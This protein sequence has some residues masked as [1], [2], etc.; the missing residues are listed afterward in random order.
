MGS[1]SWRDAEDLLKQ[2]ALGNLSSRKFNV[3]HFPHNL[4]WKLIPG[5]SYV[6][7]TSSIK[8][9][10]A[11]LDAAVLSASPRLR[12]YETLIAPELARGQ[13]NHSGVPFLLLDYLIA[14]ALLLTTT[15]QEWLDRP[16]DTRLP[17]S[18]SRTVQKWLAI[19]HSK[20]LPVEEEQE[21]GP[22]S[23]NAGN[24]PSSPSTPSTRRASSSIWD[25]HTSWSSNSGSGSGGS[26]QVATPSTPATTPSTHSHSSGFSFARGLS[27]NQQEN[28]PPVPPLPAVQPPSVVQPP[29]QQ[30][31][32]FEIA[33]PEPSPDYYAS[34]SGSEP[35]PYGSQSAGPSPSYDSMSKA[36]SSS[37]HPFSHSPFAPLTSSSSMSSVRRPRQLP[38]PP[39]LQNAD[40]YSQ[41]QASELSRV[42]SSPSSLPYSAHPSLHTSASYANLQMGSGPRSAGARSSMRRSIR[43]IPPPPPPPQH[44]PPLPL[45]PKLA[46]E[47]NR[48]DGPSGSQIAMS[49]GNPHA[50]LAMALQDG[51][52]VNG[53][54]SMALTSPSSAH[55][56][57]YSI[58]PQLP[59]FLQPDPNSG[60]DGSMPHMDAGRIRASFPHTPRDGTEAETE[61]VFEMPPPAYDD[62]DFSL[63][64]RMPGVPGRGRRRGV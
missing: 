58:P 34:T 13:Q 26:E 62:I 48:P 51:E 50:E 23:A 10:I 39:L 38:K 19:I 12:I 40:A 53:M 63:R 18:S 43:S 64:V 47:F 6:C 35:H 4:K 61:S 37:S 25:T 56:H 11:I 29:P 28:I 21:R 32:R 1:G 5:N 9:P 57:P 24:E 45:P 44:A 41:P 36:S 55:S 46:V 59:H 60:A 22:D 49:S 3:P 54:A 33:N 16:A 15:N 52:L 42:A 31:I 8:G 30:G 17:G 7:S 2:S 27:P 14:T 20:P